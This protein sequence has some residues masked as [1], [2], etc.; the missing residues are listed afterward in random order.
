[1][2]ETSSY[3][4]LD[5]IKATE[6]MTSVTAGNLT[7]AVDRWQMENVIEGLKA[8][9]WEQNCWSKAPYESW[10]MEE[11]MELCLR[12]EDAGRTFSADTEK[13]GNCPW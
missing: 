12:D 2:P 1:M 5:N 4:V 8:L 10:K 11:E 13:V 7:V 9:S 6:C 3:N